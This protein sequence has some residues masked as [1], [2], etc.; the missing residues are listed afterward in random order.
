MQ[1]LVCGSGSPLS[2]SSLSQ[3]PS[4]LLGSHGNRSHDANMSMAYGGR[5]VGQRLM[6]FTCLKF[7]SQA[8]GMLED[9]LAGSDRLWAVTKALNFLFRLFPQAGH[10]QA[11][12]CRHMA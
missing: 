7:C 4:C 3:R 12:S 10:L 8:G 9:V 2:N 6:G 11:S 5:Q 1:A